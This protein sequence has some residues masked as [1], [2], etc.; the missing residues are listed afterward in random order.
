M[1]RRTFVATVGTGVTIGI[2]GCLDGGAEAAGDH[3]VGMTI[4]SFRPEELTVEAGTTVTFRN[5]SSHGHTVTAFQDAYPDEAEYFASGGYA[6]E[7][8][9]RR[10]YENNNGGVLDQG[11]RFEH[12]FPVPG[13]YDYFCIPHLDVDMIGAIEV[14]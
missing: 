1:D 9:A 11:D 3:D 2:A 10:D 6:T 4:D 5:T 13:R 8:A 12:E 7:A 14:E